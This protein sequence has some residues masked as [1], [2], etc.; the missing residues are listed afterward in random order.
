MVY[1]EISGILS[2]VLLLDLEP[3]LF[4]Q[5][6]EQAVGLFVYGVNDML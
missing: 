5:L 2:D 6:F 4:K 3:I 1:P